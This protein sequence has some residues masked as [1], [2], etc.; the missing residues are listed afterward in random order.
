[1]NG[2]RLFYDFEQNQ[3]KLDTPV[4]LNAIQLERMISFTRDIYIKRINGEIGERKKRMQ[5]ALL[6]L[7]IKNIKQVLSG[8]GEKTLFFSG[9]Y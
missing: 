4:V 1:M 5:N 2:V 8:P 6:K 7:N 3:W 9:K